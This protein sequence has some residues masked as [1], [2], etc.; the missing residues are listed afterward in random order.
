LDLLGDERWPERPQRYE[1][2]DLICLQDMRQIELEVGGK[3]SF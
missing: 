3:P 2:V 1:G